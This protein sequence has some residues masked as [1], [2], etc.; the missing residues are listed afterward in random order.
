MRQVLQGVG[1]VL[2][3]AV[4]MAIVFGCQVQEKR[5]SEVGWYQRPDMASET[6]AELKVPPECRDDTKRALSEALRRFWPPRAGQE[7][8]VLD[9]RLYGEVVEQAVCWFQLH[10]YLPRS[11][12]QPCLEVLD[13]WPMGVIIVALTS[14]RYARSVKDRKGKGNFEMPW[15]VSVAFGEDEDGFEWV[16]PP[17]PGEVAAPPGP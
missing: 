7:S 1:W 16:G 13:E 14:D 8:L 3:E 17:P 5:T 4:L 12:E 10:G 6:C 15:Y 11:D 2:L 9:R